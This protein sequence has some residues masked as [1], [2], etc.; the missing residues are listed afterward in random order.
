MVIRFSAGIG[1][2]AALAAVAQDRPGC[3]LFQPEASAAPAAACISC[4]AGHT[5][6]GNHSVDIDY[7]SVRK[8]DLRPAD[9][10]LRLGVRIP[11]GKVRCTTCHDAASP[12]KDR[13]ALPPGAKAVRAVDLHNPASYQG[14]A[15][16]AHPGEPVSPKPLCLACHALD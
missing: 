1:I 5:G 6:I 2:A 3:L 10:V 4:H 12:W 11:E 16:A 13:I 9:E 7:A 8:P 14:A 15:A